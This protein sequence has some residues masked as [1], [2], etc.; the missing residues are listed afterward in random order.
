MKSWKSQLNSYAVRPIQKFSYTTGKS[1]TDT[2][3]IIDAMDLLHGRLVDGFCIVSS[4]S[5]FTGL[6]HRIREEGLFI[7]GI[8][9]SHTPEAFQRSCE[10]FTFSEILSAAPSATLGSA[11]TKAELSAAAAEGEAAFRAREDFEPIVSLKASGV[12][13]AIEMLNIQKAFQ[14]AVDVDTSQAMLSRLSEA[15]RSQDPAFDHRNYGY[16]TFKQFC[17]AL[18]NY[19]LMTQSDKTTL[20]LREKVASSPNA[21][22]TESTAAA[23][24]MAPTQPS[25]T[26]KQTNRR[27]KGKRWHF[28]K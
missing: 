3:L 15:L 9:K 4:D 1:S 23:S 7:M 28:Y 2:A 18:P 26:P 16:K 12:V 24:G 19:E 27:N 20:V 22:E 21:T 11:S 8:G 10:Q 13:R 5:D 14:V 6:A 25:K 17:M